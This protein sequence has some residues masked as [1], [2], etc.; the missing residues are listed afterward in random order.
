M[1][2][3]ITGVFALLSGDGGHLGGGGGDGD[4]GVHTVGNGL[5]GQLAQDSLIPLAGGHL[6]L[7]RDAVFLRDASS[8]AVIALAIS[9]R[10]AWSI[11]LITATL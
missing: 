2:A 10:E 4:N 1:A 9:S 8:R 3:K 7:D 6:I 11:C 5:V